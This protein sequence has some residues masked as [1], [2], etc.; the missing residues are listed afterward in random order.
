MSFRKLLLGNWLE[1]NKPFGVLA[2]GL[3][4]FIKGGQVQS[5]FFNY[6]VECYPK[7]PGIR[8]DDRHCFQYHPPVSVDN[9][10]NSQSKR[11]LIVIITG[12]KLW[13]TATGGGCAENR[14]S[15][16]PEIR[17]RLNKP[18]TIVHRPLLE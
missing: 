14:Q 10:P 15:E 13:L 5:S 3:T 9:T 16:G 4:K 1:A 17:K 11:P 12:A 18:S 8:N 7:S 6:S 2:P